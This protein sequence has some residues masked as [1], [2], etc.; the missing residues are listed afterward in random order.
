MSLS[1]SACRHTYMSAGVHEG[2]KRALGSLEPD[3]GS[4]L[5]WV[6]G[7]ELM[8]SLNPGLQPEVSTF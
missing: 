7:T 2:L 4:H 8:S 1:V 6:Q 3:V 5:T